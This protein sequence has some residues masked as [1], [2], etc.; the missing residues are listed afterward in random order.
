MY[1]SIWLVGA[2][3]CPH[4]SKFG[5]IRIVQLVTKQNLSKIRIFRVVQKIF[6]G[7]QNFWAATRTYLG[8]Q[9]FL[10]PKNNYDLRRPF[11][12]RSPLVFRGHHSN[13]HAILI[14]N[15]CANIYRSIDLFISPL[16][17]HKIMYKQKASSIYH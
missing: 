15:L 2:D 6:R 5:N 7:N 9:N 14:K 3:F 10:S 4:V 17:A 13:L 11:F 1:I 8:K 12:Q 16:R